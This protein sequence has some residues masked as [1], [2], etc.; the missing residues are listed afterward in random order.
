[1][2]DYRL[3]QAVGGR[4]IARAKNSKKEQVKNQSKSNKKSFSSKRHYYY[5]TSTSNVASGDTKEPL[6]KGEKLLGAPGGRGYR[7]RAPGIGGRWGPRGPG[8]QKPDSLNPLPAD[9]RPLARLLEGTTA[10]FLGSAPEGASIG[11]FFDIWKHTEKV[12]TSDVRR[13]IA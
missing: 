8:V 5:G 10:G 13:W 12:S 4:F 3:W 1:M 7:V 6:R 9:P 2:L 11:F